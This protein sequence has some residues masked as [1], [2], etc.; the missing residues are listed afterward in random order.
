METFLNWCKHRNP[1]NLLILGYF[2]ILIIGFLFLN[3]PFFQRAETGVMDSLFIATSALSTTGLATIGIGDAYNVGGH[4]VILLLIQIGGIGYMSLGSFVVMMRHKKLSHLSEDLIHYD[5][6]L[7]EN[8][9]IAGFIKNM[10]FF[11]VGIELI[12]AIFLSLIFYSEGVAYPIWN[13]VF[14]SISAF[15]TAGFS[16]FSNGFEDYYGNFYLNAVIGFLSIAGA[17]GFIVFTDWMDTIKGKK[18]QITLTSKI[19]LRVTFLGIVIGTLVLFLSDSNLDRYA[20]EERLMIAFF[21]SM[22][23]FTTVGFNTYPIGDLLAAPLF[24]IILL[25][26]VGASPSGTGGGLK[27]TTLTA[28]FAQLKSTLKGQSGAFYM[29]KRIPEHRIRMATSN[30]VFYGLVIC[31]GIYLLLLVQKQDPF[32]VLFEA[33]SALGTV[34]I[35]TGLTGDLTNLG[36]IIIMML[37]F[38]GR[39]GPLSFGIALFK[40]DKP[41]Q[42]IQEED[43]AI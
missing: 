30:F 36:K 17:I 11:T 28:L 16:L 43:I 15:C 1:T 9:N 3:I 7:P 34:G 13:G 20:T 27:S 35:S 31:I 5:F 39:I 26:I 32:D 37:M 29:Q 8:F 42:K 18:E 21:Q 6:S 12:G 23:A 41:N 38:L 2:F 40:K 4:L 33:V 25:M 19:I 22:T 14:H 24:F 10:V